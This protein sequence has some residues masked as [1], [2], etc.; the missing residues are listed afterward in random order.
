MAIKIGV[1]HSNVPLPV[2][3]RCGWQWEQCANISVCSLELS[4][5][6]MFAPVVRYKQTSVICPTK[7][8]SPALKN[9]MLDVLMRYLRIKC[10][11]KL[12][13]QFMAKT[14]WVVCLRLSL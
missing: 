10:A 2:K 11:L 14:H 6:A 9:R 13:G 5:G 8:V 12:K 7:N 1:R 4:W 3:P